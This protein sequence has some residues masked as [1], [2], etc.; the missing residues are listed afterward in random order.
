M[1]ILAHMTLCVFLP[2][3]DQSRQ[4]NALASEEAGWKSEETNLAE[5]EAIVIDDHLASSMLY[6][7]YIYICM[8]YIYTHIH[9]HM[10]LY[11]YIHMHIYLYIYTCISISIYIHN[12]PMH[13]VI[14]CVYI[15]IDMYIHH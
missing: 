9:I 10:Y 3:N 1:Q 7:V 15:Y 6:Y 8:D 5:P 4:G 2:S 12:I 13:C 14:L 11:I